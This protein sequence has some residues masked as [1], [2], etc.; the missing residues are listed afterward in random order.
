MME[1]PHLHLIHHSHLLLRSGASG[2][3]SEWSK[4]VVNFH[5][6][7]FGRQTISKQCCSEKTVGKGWSPLLVCECLGSCLLLL[8]W[9]WG[10]WVQT[11]SGQ[12]PELLL[13]HLQCEGHLPEWGLIRPWESTV[14]RL[15]NTMLEGWRF[16]S[17]LLLVQVGKQLAQL[18]PRPEP[19]AL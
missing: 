5:V 14:L 10:V 2:C 6:F 12:I 4:V 16:S 18:F 19:H 13:N 1:W 3:N 11:S 9:G 15:R 7:Y 8:C 17:W